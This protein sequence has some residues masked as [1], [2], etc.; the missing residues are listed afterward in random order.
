MSA[1]LPSPA[2]KLA[3]GLRVLEDLL[4]KILKTFE[5]GAEGYDEVVFVG[6][7]PFH[8]HCEHHLA[9]FFGV[10]HIGYLPRFKIV[11][12]SKLPRLVDIY[13]RRLTVQERITTQ[14]ADAINEHLQARAVGV[15]L[16]CRHLCMESRGINRARAITYTSA[17]R[18]LFKTD[19]ALRAEFMTLVKR[20][21][22]TSEP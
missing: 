20:A 16:R 15:V 10:A 6:A 11:G 18:G 4:S 1:R 21:D 12:L 13:A 17:L 2:S 19:T 8:A 7:I 5:D 22:E 9:P 14:V 3:R